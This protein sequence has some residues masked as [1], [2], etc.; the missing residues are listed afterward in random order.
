[1]GELGLAGVLTL[2]DFVKKV[3]TAMEQLAKST[4][5][6]GSGAGQVQTA[7]SPVQ[8]EVPS[9]P[10]ADSAASISPSQ[11]SEVPTA[12]GGLQSA[13][14][15]DGGAATSAKLGKK[16]SKDHGRGFSDNS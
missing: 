7:V 11:I 16:I 9:S 2:A 6:S 3:K 8:L 12:F 10:V 5:L 15:K 4:L 13:V 1:M 14:S